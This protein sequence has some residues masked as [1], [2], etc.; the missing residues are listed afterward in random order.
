MKILLCSI[1]FV[2][3]LDSYALTSSIIIPCYYGHFKH[4]KKLLSSLSKQTELPEEVIVS[5]SECDKIPVTEVE[6]LQKNS[7]PFKL[8]II[9][10]RKKLSAGANR[11]SACFHAHGDILICQDADDLPHP[12]RI[13][14]IKYFF[15]HYNIAH[16]IHRWVDFKKTD[17]KFYW[18]KYHKEK[19]DFF[20]PKYWEQSDNYDYITHGNIAIKKDVFKQIRWSTISVGEDVLFNQHVFEK[21]KKTII[22]DAFLLDYRSYLS[23]Q[24]SKKVHS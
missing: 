11:N 4:L 7:Y 14:I 23:S 13:E 9:K 18:E 21:F 10:H 6:S 16:L 15:S 1:Y 5:L 3:F 24:G 17:T 2:I 8:V 22:I 20:Y 19:I 12:Q